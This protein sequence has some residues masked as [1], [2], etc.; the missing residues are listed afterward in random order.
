MFFWPSVGVEWD[1]TNFDLIGYTTPWQWLLTPVAKWSYSLF[2]LANEK[3]EIITE[4]W[5]VLVFPKNFV[6]FAGV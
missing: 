4:T 5:Y 6:Q 2:F 1:D 3:E